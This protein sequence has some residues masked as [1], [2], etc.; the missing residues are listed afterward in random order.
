MTGGKISPTVTLRVQWSK[1]RLAYILGW[2]ALGGTACRGSWQSLKT[3]V[4][5]TEIHWSCRLCGQLVLSCRCPSLRVMNS[6]DY[7]D[8]EQGFGSGAQ[9]YAQLSNNTLSSHQLTG[10]ECV[11]NVWISLGYC[12]F[13][14]RFS[15]YCS[16][17]LIAIDCCYVGNNFT[18]VCKISTIFTT[19]IEKGNLFK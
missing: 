10:Q 3:L 17:N 8:W 5:V 4:E 12:S 15:S 19:I 13:K 7:K 14:S 9:A 18:F 6:E 16:M 2:E 11:Y 1:R